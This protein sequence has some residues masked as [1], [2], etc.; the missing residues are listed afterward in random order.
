MNM[1]FPNLSLLK[2]VIVVF[3]YSESIRFNI[4]L[5]CQTKKGNSQLWTRT[6]LGNIFWCLE[7]TRIRGLASKEAV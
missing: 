2:L 7:V 5:D 1:S 6:G 4:I 3:F